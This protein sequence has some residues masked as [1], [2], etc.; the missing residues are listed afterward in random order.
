MVFYPR[1][2][3][4]TG[5]FPSLVR[6]FPTDGKYAGTQRLLLTATRIFGTKIGYLPPNLA[7]PCV[8]EYPPSDNYA[9]AVN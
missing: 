4:K 5:V 7:V 1:I 8:Q 6:S 9:W 2:S 3:F